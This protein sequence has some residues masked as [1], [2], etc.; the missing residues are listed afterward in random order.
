MSCLNQRRVRDLQK[1]ITHRAKPLKR[2]L[3]RPAR[4]E[5]QT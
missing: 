1:Q 5:P 3:S 4:W 2:L